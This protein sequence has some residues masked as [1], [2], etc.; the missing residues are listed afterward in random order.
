MEIL[1]TGLTIMGLMMLA[2]KM[3]KGIR[4]AENCIMD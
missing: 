4:A 3:E 2:N 1:L